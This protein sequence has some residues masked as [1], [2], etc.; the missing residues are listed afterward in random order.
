MSTVVFYLII[1][2]LLFLAATPF[3]SN[4]NV[5]WS[6]IA[7]L[8]VCVL[9]LVANKSGNTI[10]AGII[11]TIAFEGALGFVIFST[12][13]F[14][15]INL[16]LFDLFIVG[17]LLTVSLLP[18]VT[19]FLVGALNSLFIFI[20]LTVQ[21]HTALLA[22]VLKT[23]FSNALIVPVA[24][25]FIVA[26]VAFLW[27]QSSSRAIARADRAEMIALLEHTIAEQKQELEVGIERILQTH[28]AIANGELQARAPLTHDNVLW[29]VANSLNMLL[30]RYQRAL[31]IEKEY[32]NLSRANAS[33]IGT[34]QQA[35]RIRKPLNHLPTT[36]TTLD[37]LIVLLNGVLASRNISSQLPDPSKKP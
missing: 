33:L 6:I 4:H 5:L 37:P 17:E 30:Q 32:E 21:S 15:I 28:M 13:P 35:N 31:A 20:S 7:M 29:Q 2:L 11:I 27:L 26:G 34:I 9:A 19:V 16:R 1:I 3:L 8:G 36:G 25:Q 23:Q 18:S 14:D 10:V 12:T 22:S 24:L